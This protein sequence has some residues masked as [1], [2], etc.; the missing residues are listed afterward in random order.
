[1]RYCFFFVAI[2]LLFGSCKKETVT[3]VT[4]QKVS[5]IVKDTCKQD[6]CAEVTLNYVV[7]SGNGEASSKINKRINEFIIQ[8]LYISDDSLKI[9]KTIPE[10]IIDFIETYKK[11]KVAFTEIS[12]YFAEISVNDLYVSPNILSVEMNT[13]L[14]TG[15]AHG[16]EATTYTNF[17]AQT[18]EILPFDNL[19]TNKKEFLAL[20]EKTFRKENEIPEGASINATGFWFENDEFY[21]PQSFGIT[22]EKIIFV[23]NQYEIASYA[24]GPIVLSIPRLE[25]EPFFKSPFIE[26]TK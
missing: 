2:L 19:V 1:M 23:Y 11:D 17:D 14:Y 18:G 25:A 12:P 13:Y 3:P 21:L 26:H 6:A 9:P 10:A 20:A 15:G 4:I 5:K 22:S 7:V 16:Y 8:S 24:A